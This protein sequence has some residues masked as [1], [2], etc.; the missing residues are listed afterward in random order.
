MEEKCCIVM[1]GKGFAVPDRHTDNEVRL[2]A[3][4]QPSGGA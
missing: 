3:G 2:F 4:V 1:I